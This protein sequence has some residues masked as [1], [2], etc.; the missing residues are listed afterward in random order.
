MNRLPWPSLPS[1]VLALVATAC[2][3]TIA[4]SQPPTIAFSSSVCCRMPARKSAGVLYVA[5]VQAYAAQNDAILVYALPSLK[6]VRTI[7]GGMLGTFAGNASLAVDR[8]GNLYAATFD[9][10]GS[11]SSAVAVYRPGKT[12]P[13]YEIS[14]GVD[15]PFAILTDA[16]RNLYV[17]N[18]YNCFFNN[19]HNS[20]KGSVTVYAPGKASPAY[21]I[22]DGIDNP[23]AMAVDSSGNLYVSNCPSKA[24]PMVCRANYYSGPGGGAI[25]VYRKGSKSIAY[26]ISNG[27]DAPQSLAVDRKDNLYAANVGDAE[28]AV[29]RPKAVTPSYDILLGVFDGVSPV[30]MTFDSHNDLFVAMCAFGET[31][32][33]CAFP[34]GSATTIA[35]LQ[36]PPNFNPRIVQFDAAGNLYA[37]EAGIDA[38]QSAPSHKNQVAVA[39]YPP[40]S[41]VP[42]KVLVIGTSYDTAMVLG[43]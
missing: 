31:G 23:N 39:V 34:P 13:S 33:V 15:H 36:S 1:A 4:Q 32:R 16:N 25:T 27:I 42:S 28:I 26:S 43:P 18:C 2:S 6:H 22:T 20:S 40:W 3:G 7:T 17:A 21:T 5:R 12:S 38:I 9:Q 19:G 35:F 29:Y 10:Y 41:G 8:S 14:K 11:A 24:D 30:S 37:L